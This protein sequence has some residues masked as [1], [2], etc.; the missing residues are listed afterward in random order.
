GAERE[1]CEREREPERDVR[2]ALAEAPA[3]AIL[4]VGG[5]DADGNIPACEKFRKQSHN[6]A[7]LC[8]AWEYDVLTWSQHDGK[9][10]P[11]LATVRESYRA[12]RLPAA[13]PRRAARARHT[14]ARRPARAGTPRHG[15]SPP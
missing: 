8:G 10:I 5:H 15:A 13:K 7:N 2:V 9:P 14:R 3:E 6:H 11:H 4:I 12:S 1:D